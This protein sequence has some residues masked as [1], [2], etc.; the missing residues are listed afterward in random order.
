MIFKANER[1]DQFKLE[2]NWNQEELEQW[3]L[4]ARQK[5]ED[6]LTLEKYRRAD[7]AKIKELTLQIEK[8]T[9]EVAKKANELEQEVTET[10][11]AQIEL[12][13]T[14]EEFKRLHSERHQLYLQWQ[15]TVENSRRRDELINETAVQFGERKS[16]FEKMKKDLEQHI[17]R[18]NREKETNKAT[19]TEIQNEE[20]NLIKSRQMLQN[21]D[22]E[23]KASEG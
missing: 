19:E 4:A 7:E 22:E 6:N 23:A 11:A 2:M 18:L 10:Q 1:M 17:T 15:D 8:L 21:A 13:K 5:E 3:A 14:A 12:D 20:R 16:Y 9:I